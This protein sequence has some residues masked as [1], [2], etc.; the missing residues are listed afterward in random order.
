MTHLEIENLASDYLEGLL[1]PSLRA[2]VEAHLNG[3]AECRELMGDVRHVLEMCRAAEDVE[4]KPW[5]VSKILQ[6]TIGERKP[7]WG[8][9]I[10]AYLRPVLQPRVAYPIAMTVFTFS[11]LVNAAGLNLRRLRFEDLNP[12]TWV[13]RANRQGHLMYAHAEKFYYDLRV[14]YEI[15]SRFRQLRGQS[16]G[17]EEVTPKPAAPAGGSSQGAPVDQTMASNGGTWI[18][19][20]T[21][22]EQAFPT[23][24]NRTGF[25]GAR[26]RP[27]P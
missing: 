9:R 15:E 3:C 1:E 23:E 8:E 10:S 4:P 13:D 17:Q 14:V 7:T 21:K 18:E 12:R 24:G 11:I 22:N 6:A 2:S 27:I 25:T 5:L 26:R 19:V 20:A 16:H